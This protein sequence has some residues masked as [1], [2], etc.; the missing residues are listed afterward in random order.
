M[1]KKMIN[2]CIDLF[3]EKKY[4]DALRCYDTALD[5]DPNSPWACIGKAETLRELGRLDEAL[6]WYD[7]TN[8]MALEKAAPWG[9]YK[10]SVIHYMLGNPDKSLAYLDK[11]LELDPGYHGAWFNK[12]VVLSEC[13]DMTRMPERAAEAIRCYDMEL[14]VHPDNEDAVYNKGL[15]LD[16]INKRSEALECFEKVTQMRPDHAVAHMNKGNI[17]S[18]MNKYDDAMTCYDRA[19][20]I[21]PDSAL[22]MYNK[23]RLL[24]FLD[25]VQD[26][27]EL[28]ERA[29][30]IDPNLPDLDD[31]R[32][33]L[34]ERI[35]FGR[36][37][38]KKAGSNS[39]D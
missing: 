1:S 29:V 2:R 14:E 11:V 18:S 16:L 23:S 7:N 20:Q 35:E 15:I 34:K 22:A 30:A 31:L 10:K 8:I 38:H 19:L 32:G 3:S 24:Y 25:K 5:T 17:L 39:K 33:M 37:I 28:L 9:Y 36:D 21:E 4:E 27:A 13:F 26:A 6:T 12:G